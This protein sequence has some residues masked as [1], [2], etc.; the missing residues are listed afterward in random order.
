[1]LPG[2]EDWSEEPSWRVE[3]AEEHGR[4]LFMFD[5]DWTELVR[6]VWL[7][8]GSPPVIQRRVGDVRDLSWLASSGITDFTTSTGSGLRDDTQIAGATQLESLRLITS[9]TDPIDWTRL[10][11]L[12]TYDGNHRPGQGFESLHLEALSLWDYDG[13]DL[14]LL[15]VGPALRYFRLSPARRL[16]SLA[17]IEAATALEDLT[18]GHVSATDYEPLGRLPRLADLTLAACSG[19]RDLGWVAQAT[20]LRRLVLEN[21]KHVSSFAPLLSHPTLASITITGSTRPSDG[22]YSG[23][24]R[25]SADEVYV[26]TLPR[27]ANITRAQLTDRFPPQ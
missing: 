20:S 3:S 25:A 5:G 21:C 18:L 7:D 13:V 15:P 17:G 27:T 19:V 23:L 10:R 22:D 4:A 11:R 26:E 2:G 16:R 12:R 24:L 9:R 8:A 6:Q 14:T 1:M